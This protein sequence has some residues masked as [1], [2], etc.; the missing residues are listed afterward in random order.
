MSPTAL[1]EIIEQVVKVL[2]GICV[3]YYFRSDVY[4]AVTALLL[5]VTISECVALIFLWIRF[6]RIPAPDKLLKNGAKTGIF[7]ILRLSIPVTFSACLIPLFALIDSIL[8]VRLL[9]VYE[10]NA[11][12]LYGLF[13]GGAVTI[14]NL[15][16]SVCYG[17]AAAS[18]PA[19]SASV[20][21]GKRSRKKLLYS[22]GLTFVVSL[23]SAVG[24]YFFA[25][26]AVSILFRSLAMEEAAI[27]TKLV[28]LFSV[29]AVT[30]SCTQTLSACL[31]ALGRPTRAAIAML[32][33]M[34]VKT[35]LNV[36][37]LKNPEYSIY[38]AAISAS[39]GYFLSCLLDFFFA[40]R[41]TRRGKT[42][43]T[44]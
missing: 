33:A 6:H 7:G 15:P 22:V 3:A 43:K 24:V 18:V 42:R 37:L 29:S 16:V 28:R 34:A 8:I 5:A 40:L 13:S 41:A 38:G 19:I 25:E 20:K 44:V 21:K 36:V 27:L 26:A 23:A 4:T 39:A 31:T 17:I 12:T 30:L 14:I 32:F 35:V 11:V 2:I 9:S 10:E 1:S